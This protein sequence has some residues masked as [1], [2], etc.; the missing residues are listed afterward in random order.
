[1]C[2]NM[3]VLNACIYFIATFSSGMAVGR[4]TT[5]FDVYN[6][7]L[8]PYVIKQGLHGREG[9][10]IEKA[11]IGCYLFFFYFQMVITWGLVYESDILGIFC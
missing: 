2:I 7:L 4:L 9:D 11:C 3:S 5:Y 6:L 10:F 1:M 8:L